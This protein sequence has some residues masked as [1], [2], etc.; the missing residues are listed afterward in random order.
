MILY[1]LYCQRLVLSGIYQTPGAWRGIAA[2]LRNWQF[3]GIFAAQ[4][5]QP[6][7]VTL[8]TDPTGTGTTARPKRIG[9]G[10][11]PAGQRSVNR[12]FDNT[13]FAA[14]TCVCF[15]NSGRGIL[16]S[17][18]L[19]NLDFSI[20]REF[21]FNERVHLQL[22]FE[23]FNLMNHP[24]FGLPNA[25]IGNPQVGII[26]SVVNPEAAESGRGETAVLA[27]T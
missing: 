1:I 4:T 24:N 21:A 6:F 10:T 2:L 11:L 26:G 19:V 17:P 18:G 23:S 9:D 25:V 15:G 12:W 8:S 22:R 13:A 20:R 3:A 16:R 5:G 7:T 14:P 27:S